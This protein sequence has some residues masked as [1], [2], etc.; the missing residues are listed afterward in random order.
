MKD[1]YTVY[2]IHFLILLLSLPTSGSGLAEDC[3]V[4]AFLC[5]IK[6]FL[7]TLYAFCYS[8]L[9]IRHDSRKMTR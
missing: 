1:D 3:A 9:T 7:A 5:Q 2:M 4:K 8:W 6:R